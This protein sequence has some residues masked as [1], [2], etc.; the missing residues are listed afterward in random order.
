[1]LVLGLLGLSSGP[2]IRLG[3]QMFLQLMKQ[4]VSEVRVLSQARQ[5]LP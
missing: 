5:D 1:M 2:M 4:P 3:E